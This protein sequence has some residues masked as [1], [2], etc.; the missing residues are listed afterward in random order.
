MDYSS[1]NSNQGSADQELYVVDDLIVH[2][3]S[4]QALVFSN[5]ALVFNKIINTTDAES[6]TLKVS[7]E[8]SRTPFMLMVTQN[9]E[10]ILG[11]QLF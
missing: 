6:E 2:L 11:K 5:K 4:N 3:L 9:S 7:M 8:E 1:N 10:N